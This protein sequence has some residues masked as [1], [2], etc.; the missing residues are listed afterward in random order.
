MNLEPKQ[1]E[2]VEVRKNS[3]VAGSQA[4]REINGAVSDITRQ[5]CS[6]STEDCNPGRVCSH[7][8]KEKIF[9]VARPAGVRLAVH[10]EKSISH[11]WNL[12][13]CLPLS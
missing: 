5:S 1:R 13:A 11:W 7:I 8:R 9:A 12:S 3:L 6:G 4:E 2:N 10:R